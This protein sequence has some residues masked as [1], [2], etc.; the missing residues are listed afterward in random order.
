MVAQLRHLAVLLAADAADCSSGSSG[1]AGGAAAAVGGGSGGGAKSSGGGALRA[2][3]FLGLCSGGV[4]AS[5]MYNLMLCFTLQ[6]TLHASHSTCRLQDMQ[7][8]NY[9][10]SHLN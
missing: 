2:A 10:Q 8:A 5:N 3:G 4:P 1:S 9:L 7:I 6:I